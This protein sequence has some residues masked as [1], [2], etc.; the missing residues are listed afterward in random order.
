[1]SSYPAATGRLAPAHI[2]PLSETLAQRGIPFTVVAG[3][4]PVGSWLPFAAPDR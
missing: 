2:C 3:G 1:M 4:R